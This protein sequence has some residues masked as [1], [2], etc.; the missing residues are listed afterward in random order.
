MTTATPPLPTTPFIHKGELKQVLLAIADI[1]GYTRYMT[2]NR[3]DLLHSQ[4]LLTD[5]TQTILK[6]IEFP[7]QVSKLEGDAI[8]LYAELDDSWEEKKTDISWRI[9][10]FFEVFTERLT[11]LAES[12]MCP[13]TACKKVAALR[14]KVIVHSGEALLHRI[15]PF[16]ELS[17]VDVITVHRLLKNSMNSDKYLLVTDSALPLLD[18][19]DGKLD[20]DWTEWYDQL[21]EVRGKAWVAEEMEAK[22][23]AI[24]ESGKYRTAAARLRN[25]WMKVRKILSFK[26]RPSKVP[27]FEHLS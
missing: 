9:L 3:T 14:L 2:Q 21:G 16:E 24:V 15:G 13:C 18:F 10:S 1:S 5:L 19:P 4:V 11:E 25:E 7:L 17:G 6:E 27:L 26:T 23:Q 8:F 12:N 22:R 20:V